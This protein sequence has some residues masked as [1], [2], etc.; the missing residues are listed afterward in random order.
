MSALELYMPP[1]FTLQLH[2]YHFIMAALMGVLAIVL[3]NR[4]VLN[5]VA[6]VMDES[7]CVLNVEQNKLGKLIDEQ[8]DALTKS[9]DLLEARVFA[10]EVALEKLRYLSAEQA[11]E[12]SF[13]CEI[14]S[15]AYLD[16]PKSGLSY[17]Q[18][19][20]TNYLE[21]SPATA[22]K[23]LNYLTENKSLIDQRFFSYGS[24]LTIHEVN[25]VLYSTMNKGLITKNDASPPVWSIK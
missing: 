16:G 3:R 7:V 22:R 18:Q 10:T 19:P 21:K 14:A 23:I 13:A 1:V 5:Q 17:M 4:F 8:S 9:L 11:E 20:L 15:S 2:P 25:S 12:T 24:V 6:C